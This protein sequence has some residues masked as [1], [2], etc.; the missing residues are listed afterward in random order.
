MVTFKMTWRIG[1]AIILP[2]CTACV[3][4]A[5]TMP[6]Y[7]VVVLTR[8]ADG[9]PP[10]L[11]SV[12]MDSGTQTT[13]PIEGFSP[14]AITTSVDGSVYAIDADEGRWGFAI[15]RLALN[16]DAWD[17]SAFTDNGF[18]TALDLELL[19]DDNFV[20]SIDDGPVTEIDHETGALRP[21]FSGYSDR[22]PFRVAVDSLGAVIG[23]SLMCGP[24]QNL[25]DWVCT[26]SLSRLLPDATKP[27]R[28]D[29]DFSLQ[30]FVADADNT[31]LAVEWLPGAGRLYRVDLDTGTATFLHE[32]SALERA[33]R[34]AIDPAN[35]ILALTG[36]GTLV[37]L[38]LDAGTTEV[39]TLDTSSAIDMD[40]R[41]V[42]EPST[43][44]LLLVGVFGTL[45]FAWPRQHPPAAM[46]RRR[47]SGIAAC[48]RER[49]ECR[50]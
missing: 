27:E 22:G 2:A 11:V 43:S 14:N 16:T 40:I 42:P 26:T 31:L 39:L 9:Q 44:L 18:F 13:M 15:G 29:L 37:R 3:L 10:A 8:P 4:Y 30:A 46:C 6:P 32:N 34:L 17:I 7:E 24:G 20:M 49:I 12:D 21:L 47:G 38:D 25:D 35:R 19:P 41:V 45:A 5:D 23:D 36:G 28:I 48:G 33:H 50:N 1:V